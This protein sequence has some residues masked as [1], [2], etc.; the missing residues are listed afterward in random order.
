MFGWAFSECLVL[1]PAAFDAARAF[2][3]RR[4]TLTHFACLYTSED[5]PSKFFLCKW[6]G[7]RAIIEIFIVILILVKD[8]SGFVHCR[9]YGF[10]PLKTIISVPVHCKMCGSVTDEG[11]LELLEL[12][13]VVSSPSP[14]HHVH[15]Q[16]C[17]MHDVRLYLR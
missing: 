16:F 10:E 6:Y 2:Y 9:S 11:F 12:A 4:N 13:E 5:H 7:A 8:C 17:M 3:S 14:D 1:V 15:I